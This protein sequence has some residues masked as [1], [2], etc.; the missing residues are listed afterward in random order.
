MNWPDPLV[1]PLSYQSLLWQFCGYPVYGLV[2]KA[3]DHYYSC[4][5]RERAR[6]AIFRV[7]LHTAIA[8][9]LGAHSLAVRIGNVSPNYPFQLPGFIEDPQHD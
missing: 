5:L 6:S 4:M 1:V 7:A 2:H 8:R 3:D 9:E